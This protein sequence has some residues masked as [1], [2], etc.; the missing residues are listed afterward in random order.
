VKDVDAEMDRIS[1]GQG[2][3]PGR[4]SHFAT[5]GRP[6]RFRRPR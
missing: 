2:I 3:I 1:E 4:I 6:D 5:C